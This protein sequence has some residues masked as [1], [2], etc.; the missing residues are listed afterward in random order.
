MAEVQIET[1]LGTW[2]INTHPRNI[3]GKGAYGIVY[4][5]T[6]EDGTEIAAKSLDPEK[7]T[8]VDILKLQKPLHLQHPNVVK[9]F[10]ISLNNSGFWMVMEYCKYGDLSKF[11]VS[12]QLTDAE[13]F[14]IMSQT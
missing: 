1:T 7:Q 10:D 9:I 3:V 5:G 2:K 14:D 13:I 8:K 12:R 4:K 11:A 6:G